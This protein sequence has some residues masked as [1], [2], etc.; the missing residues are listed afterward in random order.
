MQISISGKQIDIGSSL[1]EHVKDRLEKGVKKYFDRA[2]NSNV[3]FSKEAHLFR[4]D[5]LVNEGTGKGFII[6]GNS[7]SDDIYTAFDSALLRIEKQLRKYK[8]KIKDHHKTKISELPVDEKAI[9]KGTK[10]VLSAANANE[11]E[12]D[13]P[14][15]IAEKDV[16]IEKLSVGE[17]VMKMDL[18]QLPALMFINNKTGRVNIVYHREDGNISWVDPKL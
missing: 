12:H 18:S 11:E 4:A 7:S 10:Y 3:V 1:Q 8:N 6:K 14:V 9:A 17:A 2:V 13:N 16:T 15:I 5:I